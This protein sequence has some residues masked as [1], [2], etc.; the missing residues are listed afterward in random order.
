[1]SDPT[2][3]K[4]VKKMYDTEPDPTL[5]RFPRE[6]TIKKTNWDDTKTM[7]DL[8]IRTS[9]NLSQAITLTDDEMYQLVFVVMG[10]LAPRAKQAWEKGYEA[11]HRDGVDHS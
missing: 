7:H 10:F 11:G 9:S 5:R 4:I 6:F 1:M 2:V 3:A 8:I